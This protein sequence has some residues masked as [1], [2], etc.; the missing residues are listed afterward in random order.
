[1]EIVDHKARLI[2]GLIIMAILT[3]ILSVVPAIDSAKYLNEAAGK[4]N[5][6]MTG[7]FFQFL[8]ASIYLAIAALLYPILEKHGKSLAIGFLAMRIIAA[9]LVIFGTI[10]LSS[11]LALSQEFVQS[12][13]RNPYM[14]EV[15]GDIIKV[16]R[17]HTNH[18]YM[19]L[20]LCGGNILM[21]VLLIKS[22]MV[23][24]W[25]SA[26]GLLGVLLSAAASVLI[27]FQ[28]FDVISAQYLALNAPTALVEIVFALWLLVKGFET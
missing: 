14:F 13:S 11:L 7:A 4:L 9:T 15:L 16:A 8:M 23:P 21:Y 12:P 22:R 19:I 5:Q 26:W 28:V 17:D 20:A 10:M 24:F 27:L 3:G 18:G 6:T 2:G 25:I 1:M